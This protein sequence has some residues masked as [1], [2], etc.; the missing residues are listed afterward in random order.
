[1]GSCVS[2]HCLY[3]WTYLLL[4]VRPIR[5]PDSCAPSDGLSRF[6]FFCWHM[7]PACRHSDFLIEVIVVS[8]R[9]SFC[10]LLLP[11]SS[12]PPTN[13]PFWHRLSRARPASCPRGH[14]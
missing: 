14:Y 6:S 3:F 5:S 9:H 10:I 8:A 4:G 11:S 2:Q 1:M 7:G 12:S 13:P